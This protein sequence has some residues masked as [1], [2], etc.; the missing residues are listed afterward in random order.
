MTE[1]STTIQSST[2]RG[3]LESWSIDPRRGMGH[4]RLIPRLS[5]QCSASAEKEF[6][7][8][9]IYR[10]IAD[11]AAVDARSA[12]GTRWLKWPMPSKSNAIV[13]SVNLAKAEDDQ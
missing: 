8:C 7:H 10:L 5:P 2:R 9:L 11:I 6:P 12:E 1:G 3:H 13:V 4:R